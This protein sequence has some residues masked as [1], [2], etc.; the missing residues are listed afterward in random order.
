MVPGACHCDHV[1]PV[2]EDL[3]WLPVSQLVSSRKRCWFGSCSSLRQQ[4]LHACHIHLRLTASAV[5]S[6]WN[7][8]GSVCPDSNWMVKFRHE[9][10]NHLEWSAACITVPS[11]VTECLQAG[12]KDVFVLI[13]PALLSRFYVILALDIN[14]FS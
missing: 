13:C 8:F 10:T 12:F 3:N 2:V 6:V 4:F 9:W 1:T 14:D 7:S 5:C 11:L